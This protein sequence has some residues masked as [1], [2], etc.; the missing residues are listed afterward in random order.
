MTTTLESIDTTLFDADG[1]VHEDLLAIAHRLSEKYRALKVPRLLDTLSL[2]NSGGIFPS[3]GPL[4]QM[5]INPV[6]VQTRTEQENGHDPASWEYF[7]D[8]VGISK[9]VL[10][11]TGGLTI[12][13]VRDL[14]YAVDL[15]RAYNDWIAETYIQHPSGKFQAAAILPM[16]VPEE[17]VKELERVVN[18][19][20]FR[21]AVVPSHGLANH[22]GSPQFFPV[23]EAAQD[24]DVGIACHGGVHDGFGFDDFN[25]F[26]P[27]HALGHPFSLL[28]SL[29]GMLFNGVFDRFPRL[30]VAYL[31]GGSGWILMAAERFSESFKA[32]Q[33]AD[34]SATV[35]LAKG[36][37]VSGYL[38][39]LM[40]NDRLVMGCEGGE[41]FLETAIE[42]FGCTPF[43]YSSDFPHE[44]G[45][46]S[47]LHELEELTEL[48]IS[49]VSKA[50]LRGGT[51][52]KFY[53]L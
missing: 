52:R 50:N 6:A 13:R 44:V 12:G 20:G 17:A 29:G 19:L 37:S 23:Y 38:A 18:T 31:E 2:S 8:S 22:L 33:P 3:L 24:L 1:H 14:G 27:A 51:A 39:E 7:L 43:M 42:Y 49:D 41:D 36:Q 53:S 16:Q 28:I 45:V 5:P 35:Q 21:A 26:A 32:I 34:L 9:T 40:Q 15:C 25:V 11:P 46:A 30:R 48:K 10:Y 47:C 4:S